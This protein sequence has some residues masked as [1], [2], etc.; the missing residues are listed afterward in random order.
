MAPLLAKDVWTAEVWDVLRP[1]YDDLKADGALP[2]STG[3]IF[4]SDTSYSNRQP[5]IFDS[6]LDRLQ[7]SDEAR[8]YHM[9]LTWLDFKV[10]D[11][12]TIAQVDK[13]L[14]LVNVKEFSHTFCS[15]TCWHLC[16]LAKVCGGGLRQGSGDMAVAS[17]CAGGMLLQ[18]GHGP[19]AYLA[20]LRF[21]LVSGSLLEK[22]RQGEA[23]HTT[24]GAEVHS[25]CPFRDFKYFSDNSATAL[26]CAEA[27]VGETFEMLAE[28]FGNNTL[29]LL[30]L[31]RQVQ[32]TLPKTQKEA[33][34][35]CAFLQKNV[36]W[37]LSRRSPQ[38]ETINNLLTI[39]NLT[40]KAPQAR[41]IMEEALYTG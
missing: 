38:P 9:N 10:P 13:F 3:S 16:F 23:A 33:S 1:E 30:K 18:D 15:W 41:W 22:L 11:D 4:R 29:K 40:D 34:D 12:L 8:G 2:A 14:D 24:V 31:V 26:L 37:H 27:S 35:I 21:A 17:E 25:A 6:V 7:K 5:L 19:E 32:R 28:Y 36:H 20:T 39:S